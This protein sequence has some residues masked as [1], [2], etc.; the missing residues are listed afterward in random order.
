V[1]KFTLILVLALTAIIGV[2]AGVS[3][4][5]ATM[6][7]TMVWTQ[8]SPSEAGPDSVY[9]VEV[10]GCRLLCVKDAQGVDCEPCGAYTTTI[11]NTPQEPTQTPVPPTQTP[12]P[13]T[14]TPVP[15]TQTPVPPTQTPVPP[16]NTPVNDDQCLIHHEAQGQSDKSWTKLMP[17]QAWH[18]HHHHVGDWCQGEG[19]W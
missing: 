7:Y 5:K 8:E 19:C 2:S 14:Q 12:V 17:C 15:P 18:G 16:T 11:S 9:F 13:P 4:A 10:D 6:P 3:F 1:K